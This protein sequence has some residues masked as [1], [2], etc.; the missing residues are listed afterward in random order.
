MGEALI[1][2]YGSGGDANISNETKASLGLPNNA[3]LD[4]VIKILSLQSDNYATILVSLKW[5]DNT[6]VIGE[7]I[8]MTGASGTLNYTT[9]AGGQVLFRTNDQA[10]TIQDGHNISYLDLLYPNNVSLDCPIGT[11]KTVDMKRN[12]RGNGSNLSLSNGNVIFSNFINNFT[13]SMSGGTGGGGIGWNARYEVYVYA[14][15]NNNANIQS[16][17]ISLSVPGGNGAGAEV[18]SIVYTP[19]PNTNY[20]VNVGVGGRRGYYN[21]KYAGFAGIYTGMDFDFYNTNV[22]RSGGTSRFGSVLVANGG[23][24]ASYADSSGAKTNY[25]GGG[26]GATSANW[27]CR[28]CLGNN[29]YSD[30]IW[31]ESWVNMYGTNGANGYVRL[32]NMNYK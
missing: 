6:P 31:C 30:S 21:S 27:W 1:G 26:R 14:G 2:R 9:N 19:T 25:S 10:V 12:I 4:D 17:N 22:A 13:I 11:V 20:M 18:K 24:G 3:T 29:H 32:N 28:V 15:S 5:P 16:G 8:R 23:A 7:T